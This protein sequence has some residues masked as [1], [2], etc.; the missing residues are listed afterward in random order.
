MV[1][2]APVQVIAPQ[3]SVNLTLV[4]LRDLLEHEQS[5]QI[6]SLTNEQ[7]QRPFDFATAPLWR[8]TLMQLGEES[9]IFGLVFNHMILD[10]A[11]GEIFLKELGTLYNAFLAGKP[12]PL[13]ALPIQYADFACWQREALTPEVLDARHH[14]W[15][16]W[17]AEEP[18]PLKLAID[19]PRPSVE[20][21]QVGSEWCELSADLTQKLATL[22]QQSGVTLFVTVLASFATL[23]SRYGGGEEIVVGVPFAGRTHQLLEALIGIFTTGTFPLCIDLNG[24][25][26]FLELLK[27]T[28]QTYLATLS[29]GDVPIEPLVHTLQPERNLRQHPLCRVLLN[30]LPDKPGENLKLD[31]VTIAP[32]LT[33]GIIG[34]DLIL[35]VWEEMAH[36]GIALRARWR[37]RK[38]VFDP[39]TLAKLSNDFRAMLDQIAEHPEQSVDALASF[40]SIEMPVMEK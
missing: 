11:S 23:L 32:L 30:W 26:S 3:L 37:Y 34:R 9:F 38:D 2:D 33:E 24:H 19:R 17:L 25:P 18:P 13:P 5:T 29:N 21:R 16:Q 22:S 27:R 28:Q 36:D 10:V 12:S 14:Y 20:T 35:N 4:D 40:A 1:N 39:E 7:A 6:E 8:V 31:S 15:K